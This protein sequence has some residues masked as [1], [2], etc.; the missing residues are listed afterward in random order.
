MMQITEK[1]YEFLTSALQSVL[2]GGGLSTESAVDLV[3]A[4]ELLVQAHGVDHVKL[5]RIAK[6]VREVNKR[7]DDDPDSA[8]PRHW[9][10]RK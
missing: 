2:E 3:I 9:G 10:W 4:H 7:R 6:P 5:E 1:E 8:I